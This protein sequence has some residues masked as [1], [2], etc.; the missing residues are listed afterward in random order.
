MASAKAIDPERGP[1]SINESR[2]TVMDGH[3]S[4]HVTEKTRGLERPQ[5]GVR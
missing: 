3:Q 1:D 5:V 2:K 4:W